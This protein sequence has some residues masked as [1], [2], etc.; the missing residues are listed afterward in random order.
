MAGIEIPNLV[1]G[2]V[3]V[4]LGEAFAVDATVQVDVHRVSAPCACP[5]R[6]D[7]GGIPE[8]LVDRSA[9]FIVF[10]VEVRVS[11]ADAEACS[12]VGLGG[13][14]D[15]AHFRLVDVVALAHFL[16]SVLLFGLFTRGDGAVIDHITDAIVE[17]VRAH[18]EATVSVLGI[19][20]EIVA[21]LGFEVE[22]ADRN[23]VHG[24]GRLG[25][26]EFRE[27]GSAKSGGIGGSEVQTSLAIHEGDVRR[28][29][30][31]EKFVVEVTHPS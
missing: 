1:G 27:C 31:L 15:A 8:T 11:R 22:V 20:G 14:V 4:G 3:T 7:V 26:V 17:E 6:V 28:G 24:L 5:L 29:V 23:A 21:L 13:H 30:A 12:E 19:E 9:R 2:S 10:R 18:R 25:G 16:V